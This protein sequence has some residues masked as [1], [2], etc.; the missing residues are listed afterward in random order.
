MGKGGCWGKA[1]PGEGRSTK[2]VPRGGQNHS[3][4]TAG[5]SDV[6]EGRDE[7][8]KKGAY[9]L[10]KTN[11]LNSGLWWKYHPKQCHVGK[12]DQKSKN[13]AQSGPHHDGE[14]K[15]IP[16]GCTAGKGKRPMKS[17]WCWTKNGGEL[18]P[19]TGTADGNVV[20]NCIKRGLGYKES[21]ANAPSIGRALKK[22][23]P[24]VIRKPNGG[25]GSRSKRGKTGF[26]AGTEV[27]SSRPTYRDFGG[28]G[29]LEEKGSMKER[30]STSPGGRGGKYVRR[31]VPRKTFGTPPSSK[32]S[33]QGG[34]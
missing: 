5:G 34:A 23:H 26:S 14:K 19:R 4:S 22:K 13:C 17:V 24:G 30:P 3:C 21:P 25:S 16:I 32:T 12:K 11:P 15:N 7:R 2:V 33:D 1:N 6:E 20:P 31:P 10:G 27:I 28:P 18:V 9:R 8:Q 29:Q